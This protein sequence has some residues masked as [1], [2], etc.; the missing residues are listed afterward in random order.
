MPNT[1]APSAPSGAPA[2]DAGP[3]APAEPDPTA[4]DADAFALDVHAGLSAAQKSIPSRWL[5]DTHGS[6]LFEKITHLPEY[7][8]TRTELTILEACASDVADHVGPG[9]ALVEYGAGA[10]RKT[11]LVL[12]ALDAPALYA[13]ID[14]AADFLAACAAELARDYPAL[15]I[16][17]IAADFQ[18]GDIALPSLSS[19]SPRLGFFPGSTLGNLTDEEIVDFLTARRRGLGPASH[20]LLGVDLAKD[21]AILIPA[22]D[23]AQGVTAAFNLNLL[24]R[25]NR[26]LGA[27]FDLTG[28]RH[29]ARWN[30][31]ASQIEMHI[32]ATRAQRVT[33][34]AAT[35][36][37]SA[38]ESIHTEISRKFRLAG[39]DRLA[40]ESGWSIDTVWS[41][42]KDWFAVV[43]LRAETP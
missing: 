9:V 33:L 31:Q 43:L 38:G 36:T 24:A 8:V 39:L 19:D 40:R 13:P 29:E 28:F 6:D 32:V 27:D 22:Y 12:D 35:Y 7:Y 17:P 21:P 2:N 11:R 30:A 20:F 3:R 23:D 37:F 4:I 5:Y 34:D 1:A 42:E 25:M 18:A 26:E 14:I 15:N 10:L 41:D 16:H